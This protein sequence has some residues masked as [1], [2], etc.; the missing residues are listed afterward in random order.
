MALRPRQVSPGVTQ[1]VEDKRG[2]SMFADGT[3]VSEAEFPEL[4]ALMGN[5]PEFRLPDLRARVEAVPIPVWDYSDASHSHAPLM[6]MG[7]RVVR[8]FNHII[9]V[10]LDD[11]PNPVGTVLPYAGEFLPS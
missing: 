6:T 4:Y 5:P 3:I 9:K 10:R 7:A 11:S 8:E 1:L 2:A